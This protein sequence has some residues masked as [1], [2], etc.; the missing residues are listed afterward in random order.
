MFMCL[1]KRHLGGSAK[2]YPPVN[3]HTVEPPTVWKGRVYVSFQEGMLHFQKLFH[4]WALLTTGFLM[5]ERP[6]IT[7]VFGSKIAGKRELELI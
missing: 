4:I 6:L 1:L 5:D 7:T 2:A 3:Q